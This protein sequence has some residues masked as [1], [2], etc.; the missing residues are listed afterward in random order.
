MIAPKWQ[1]PLILAAIGILLWLLRPVLTPF[2]AAL[3]LAWLG[4]PLVSWLERAGRSRNAAVLIVYSIT[5]LL[6]LLGLLVLIP[7]LW[8]QAVSLLEGVPNLVVWAKQVALPW[9]SDKLHKDIATLFD[10][11]QI[12]GVVQNHWR[13]LGSLTSVL[14]AYASRSGMA[15]LLLL[16]YVVLIPLLLYYFLRDWPLMVQ[17]IRDLIPRDVEPTIS[18]VAR[19]SD[20]MLM[21]FVRGQLLVMVL[22]GAI[23]AVGLWLIGLDSGLLI[24]FLAGLMSFVPYL[25]AIIGVASAVIASLIQYGEIS[26]LL[27]VGLVFLVGQSIESYVLTP[28]LVG[29]RIGLSLPAVLFS[30]MAGGQ[31][32]GFIGIMLALPAAAVLKVVLA[33]MR[34]RY[35]KSRIYADRPAEPPELPE[36]A[37]PDV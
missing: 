2:V 20:D 18:Q 3:M 13:E 19:E 6:I 34:Q 23:Y 8:Q 32:F 21:A 30:I 35:L 37:R 1:M 27:W 31:L 33:H 14:L 10:P 15:L 36:P 9:L 7:M 11:T 5:T 25:G 12:A 24:G 29:D 16:S 28:R 22:L 26:H 17:R 4:N